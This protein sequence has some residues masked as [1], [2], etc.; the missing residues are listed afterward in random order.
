MTQNNLKLSQQINNDINADFEENTLSAKEGDQELSFYD[1]LN[2]SSKLN[3][4]I[5]SQECTT[6]KKANA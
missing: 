6:R 2:L 1:V 5:F 4:D 3:R